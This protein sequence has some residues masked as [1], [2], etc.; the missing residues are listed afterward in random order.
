MV[1]FAPFGPFFHQEPQKCFW[2]D[3]ALRILACSF[4]CMLKQVYPVLCA[5]VKAAPK[6][7]AAQ[8]EVGAWPR[9]KEGLVQAQQLV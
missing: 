4:S 9:K 7:K 2:A 3:A 5:K 8:P 6:P 1:P